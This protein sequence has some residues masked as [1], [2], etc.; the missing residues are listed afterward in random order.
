MCHRLF[1]GPKGFRQLKADHIHPFS[2]GGLT[3]WDNLQL[4]CLRCNAQKSDTI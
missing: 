1:R 4:L 2:K 3:T